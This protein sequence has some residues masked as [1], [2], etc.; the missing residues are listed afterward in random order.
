MEVA[1]LDDNAMRDVR[2]T[3]G[4]DMGSRDSGDDLTYNTD[5]ALEV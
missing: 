1:L 5:K 2:N 4:A 3:A